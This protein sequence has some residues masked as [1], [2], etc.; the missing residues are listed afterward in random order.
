MEDII[1]YMLIAAAASFI[2]LLGYKM[3]GRIGEQECSTEIAKFEIDLRDLGTSLRFGARELQSY[4]LPCKVDGIY[5]F[6]FGKGARPG[7]F[8]S[9]PI[10]KD[11]LIG[12]SRNNVFLVRENDVMTYFYAG[13]FKLPSQYIC[14]R[15]KS[16]RISFFAEG[17]GNY[18]KI[19]LP[20][21]Q[22]QCS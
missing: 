10:I 4:A 3:I 2:L 1:K 18:S 15:P 12:E 16:G 14:L 13:D 9:I 8:D 5:I 20:G 11:M 21:G 6:D 19:T 7:D 17:A 22:S